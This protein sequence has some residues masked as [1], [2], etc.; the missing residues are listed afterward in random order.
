MTWVENQWSEYVGY[1]KDRGLQHLF[2]SDYLS[3]AKLNAIK[4]VLKNY[5]TVYVYEYFYERPDSETYLHIEPLFMVRWNGATEK[6]ELCGFDGNFNEPVGK[7]ETFDIPNILVEEDET[8]EDAFERVYGVYPLDYD[9]D[10]EAIFVRETEKDELPEYAT[11]IHD[12]GEEDIVEI[13]YAII[14]VRELVSDGRFHSPLTT[15]YYSDDTDMVYVFGD[16]VDASD[17]WRDPN[18]FIWYGLA[19][20]HPNRWWEAVREAG[21]TNIMGI[22][23]QEV[24]DVIVITDE[25]GEV[26]EII[27][28]YRLEEIDY[29]SGR[30]YHARIYRDKETGKKYY[31]FVSHWQGSPDY[32][33]E[34][35][36]Q[37]LERME[38]ERKKTERWMP[39]EGEW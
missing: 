21:A 32:E 35:Y 38:R 17:N 33:A 19:S 20:R 34:P 27:P 23:P 4:E 15:W 18:D 22:N 11:I 28:N 1:R 8:V 2:T 7:C 36:E 25:D 37:Y 31:V 13:E 5:Q 29:E 14:P 9:K 24:E 3:D 39:D 6:I 26:T 12:D 16:Y 10:M 30:D